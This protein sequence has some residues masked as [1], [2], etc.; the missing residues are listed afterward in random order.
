MSNGKILLA[1]AGIG[2]VAAALALLRRGFEV[3]IHEQSPQLGE[4]GAGIMLTPNAM[5]VVADL[6][7][8]EAVSAVAMEPEVS[9]YRRY[10]TGEVIMSAPLRGAMLERYGAPYFHIH[11]ADLHALL[12]DAVHRLA[13]GALRTGSALVGYDASESGVVARFGGGAEAAGALL[14][15]CDGVRS[16]VRELTFGGTTPSF[17]GQV[18]WRGL[19]PAAGLPQSLTTPG[20]TAWIGQ[21]RHIIHYRLRGGSLVNYVAVVRTAAWQEEGWNRRS[22]VAEAVAEFRSFHAD[23]VTLLES[24]DAEHCYKWGLFDRNPLAT[25]TRGRVTLL[26]DAAHPMLPFMAQGAAMSLEDALVLG[27][28][29]AALGATPEAL[30]RYEALRLPRTTQVVLDSRAATA[31]YQR[32]SGDKQAVRARNLDEVYGY[33]ATTVTP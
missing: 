18:A 28:A 20:S 22:A 30:R 5:R 4:V 3:E 29:V 16:T 26:G 25:W 33:D 14:V 19:V 24:T 8:A 31:L 1:G 23:A 32:L 6:G 2:G 12:V 11:R 27:R 7:L 9:T 21:D 13:P 10:D 17:T 15:G